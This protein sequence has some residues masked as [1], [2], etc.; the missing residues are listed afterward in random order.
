MKK[1]K[2]DIMPNFIF[3][4]NVTETDEQEVKSFV[5]DTPSNK[6]EKE[7]TI[8]EEQPSCQEES[9]ETIDSDGE[10]LSTEET[11]PAPIQFP[12]LTKLRYERFGKIVATLAFV[13]TFLTVFLQLSAITFP[14]IWL[15]AIIVIFLACIFLTVFTLGTIYKF[16][17]NFIRGMWSFLGELLRSLDSI[18]D[19]TASFYNSTE[20]IAFAGLILA[21]LAIVCAFTTKRKKSICRIVFLFISL[22]IMAICYLV[23]MLSGGATW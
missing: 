11:T 15:C 8:T 3:D 4:E 17:P 22:F 13:A 5:S 18:K 16:A 6:N 12:P 10:T 19:L 20:Y 1:R 23:L 21:V 14:L 7:N 2:D 9:D